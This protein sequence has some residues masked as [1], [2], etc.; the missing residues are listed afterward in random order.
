[1]STAN[2][3]QACFIVTAVQVPSHF[4]FAACNAAADVA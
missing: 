3:A 1:M 4:A 2:A